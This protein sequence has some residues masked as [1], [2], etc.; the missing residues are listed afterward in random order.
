MTMNHSITVAELE[1]SAEA[2]YEA[3]YDAQ[4]HAVKDLYEEALMNFRRAIEAARIAGLTD[5]V[6]RFIRRAEQ[7]RSV[8][9]S[10]F[11]FIGR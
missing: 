3:M 10:Q 4:P 1:Q 2:A 6:A 7:V 5:D 9:N 11:R 8:Y